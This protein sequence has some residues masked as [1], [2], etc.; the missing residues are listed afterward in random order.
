VAIGNEWDLVWTDFLE[1]LGQDNGIEIIAGYLEGIRD[2]NRF[3]EIAKTISRKKPIFIVKGGASLVG[4][5][6]TQSHTG[7]MAGSQRIWEAV[8]R[9]ANVIS[10]ED[11]RDMVDHVVMF[12]F[13]RDRR[14]G[15][16]IGIVTGTGG[17]AVNTV[18][19]CEEHELEIPEL[20]TTTKNVIKEVIPPYGSSVRNPVDVSVA[21]ER[22]LWLYTR[23]IQI[24]DRSDEVD[25]ILCVHPGDFK[26]D[27]LAEEIVKE[28]LNG[29]KP[30]VVIFVDTSPQNTRA[31]EILLQAGIPAFAQLRTAIKALA[32]LIKW[33]RKIA[34]RA[35]DQIFC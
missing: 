22:N 13:L 25:V 6:F 20:S 19:F 33:K 21:A 30:L 9:Q 2:G 14:I 12:S 32:S 26:G 35:K 17:L 18:D 1:Y 24:L 16:R 7:S 31:L 29:R 5:A 11:I 3:L 34:L 28:N 27:E 23:P 10:T 15:P 4:T 8:L